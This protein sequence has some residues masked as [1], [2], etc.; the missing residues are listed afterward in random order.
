MKIKD[1]FDETALKLSKNKLAKMLLSAPYKA[2]RKRVSKKALDNFHKYGFEALVQFN[3]CLTDNGYNYS[4][5]FGSLLGAVR[6]HDFIPHDD[7]IDTWMWIDDYKPELIDL[8]EHY[9]FKHKVSFSVENDRFAK[10]DT[11]EYKGVLVDI[12]Y[13]YRDDKNI[14]YCCY[15]ETQE[16]CATRSL[17]I[18]KYGG[19][20]SRKIYLP[21]SADF[22]IIEFKGIEV[23]IPSNYNE[24]LKK[25]FGDDYMTPIPGWTHEN[26]SELMPNWLCIFKEF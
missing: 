14:A 23:S 25:V 5:A 15:F 12:F 9:G 1:Y 10:E 7:D 18:E 22:K 16:G 11:F 4:L 3:K 6:E 2:Y 21:L 19:L 26:F 20:A 13:V 17:S 8:L 24:V